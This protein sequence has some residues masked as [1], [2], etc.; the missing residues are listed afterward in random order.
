MALLTA[1]QA[2]LAALGANPARVIIGGVARHLGAWKPSGR[3]L[4]AVPAGAFDYGQAVRV[5]GCDQVPTDYDQ[6]QLGSCGPNS[7]AEIYQVITSEKYSRLFAYW[8]TRA[9][10]GDIFADGGV[11]IKD[12]IMVAHTMG[13]PP[14][15]LVPYDITKY[16]VPPG[17]EAIA[18]AYPHRIT[19][20]EILGDLDHCL[21]SLVAG[22][23]FMLGFG[24][25]QSMESGDTETTGIVQVPSKSDPVIGGHAVTARK[26][27]LDKRMIQTTCHY[28]PDYGDEGCIWL[29]FEHFTGGNATDFTR[30][31]AISK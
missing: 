22:K 18:A 1:L 21:M 3:R 27:D 15:A 19:D 25:P 20:S 31:N 16:Q 17:I 29:P 5:F 28:G 13:L 24:V 6:G 11:E 7:L 26:A 23:P 30:I 2:A 8:W 9:D 12:L 14:E 4:G 10:E